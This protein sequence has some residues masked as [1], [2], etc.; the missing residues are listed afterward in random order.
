[1]IIGQKVQPELGPNK[2]DTAP[3]NVPEPEL[4]PQRKPKPPST[5][6]SDGIT[7]IESNKTIEIGRDRNKK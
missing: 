2:P 7:A 4:E 1:M 3:I 6:K 5:I